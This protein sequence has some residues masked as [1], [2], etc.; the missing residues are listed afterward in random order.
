MALTADATE[1]SPEPRNPPWIRDELILALDA[2]LT[3]KGNPPAKTSQAIQEL[4]SVLN[5]LQRALGTVGQATLRNTNGIYM[6]LMNFR[7]FD[8]VYTTDGKSGLKRGNRLEG[9]LWAEFHA[10]PARLA[11][12]AALIRSGI[13]EVASVAVQEDAAGGDQME[14]IEGRVVTR[15]HQLRERSRKIVEQKKAATLKA[16]GRL[17]CE[18]CSFDFAAR[19]GERGGGFIECHHTKPVE[20]LGDGTS[21]RLDDLA[22]LCSNCH[23]MIH[24]RR[25]WLSVAELRGGLIG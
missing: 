21:T 16:K 18:V 6:K 2:Y 19:Y 22:L 20:T 11:R 1:G 25:P 23:R 12:N 10:D 17:A 3:W 4:S 13:A 7:R 8:P 24:A 14:A 5:D 9:E 15:M